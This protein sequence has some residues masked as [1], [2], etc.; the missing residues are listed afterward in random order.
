MN[1][2]RFRKEQLAASLKLIPESQSVRS[3]IPFR[4]RKGAAPLKPHAHPQC[5]G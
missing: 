5:A 4:A 1:N 3:G 2:S